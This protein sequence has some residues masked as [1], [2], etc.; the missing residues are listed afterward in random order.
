MALARWVKAARRLEALA[1]RQ[2]PAHEQGAGVL[3]RALVCSD[4]RI[5]VARLQLYPREVTRTIFV[6][7]EHE[8]VAAPKYPK[9]PPR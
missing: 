8:E 6:V 1:L 3:T 7:A 9:P 4:A 5:R 2:L